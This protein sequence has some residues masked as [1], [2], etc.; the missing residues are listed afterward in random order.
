MHQNGIVH[1]LHQALKQLLAAAQIRTA[2]FEIFE[3][4]VDR[5]AQ[6]FQ[7]L[8]VVR[9]T[10]APRGPSLE[11][12]A[13]NLFGKI[14]DGALLAPFPNDEHAQAHGQCSRDEEPHGNGREDQRRGPRT[15]NLNDA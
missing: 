2:L 15:A 14:V 10:D 11:G 5:D 9:Q 8:R 4:F 7:R 1:R 6:L 3:Q 13:P 12:Q